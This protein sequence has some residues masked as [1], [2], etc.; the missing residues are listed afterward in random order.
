MCRHG[1]TGTS[2]LAALL[3]LEVPVRLDRGRRFVEAEQD[4][5]AIPELRRAIYL[6][7]YLAEAHLRLGRVYLR[8]GRAREAIDAFKIAIWSEETAA[9]HVALAEAYY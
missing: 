3:D 7:P 4:R 2:G 5:A 8:A 6:S 9:A 1:R